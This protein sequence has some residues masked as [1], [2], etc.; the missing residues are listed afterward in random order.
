MKA[1]PH[2]TFT[3]LVSTNLSLRHLASR[4]YSSYLTDPSLA[5]PNDAAYHSIELHQSRPI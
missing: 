4:Y 5:L 1:W 2:Q 3:N